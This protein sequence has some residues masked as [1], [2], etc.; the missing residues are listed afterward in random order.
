MQAHLAAK[1]KDRHGAHHYDLADLDLDLSA[2]QEAFAPF[3]PLW[4]K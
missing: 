1:P 4:R 2:V 3:E